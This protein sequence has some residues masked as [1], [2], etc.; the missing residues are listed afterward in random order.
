MKTRVMVAAL[1]FVGG[2]PLI[3]TNLFAQEVPP[4]R[5][6]VGPPRA[7]QSRELLITTCCCAG[8]PPSI[9]RQRGRANQLQL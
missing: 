6:P 7:L 3:S 5:V 9:R 1:G 2:L 8:R 4:T